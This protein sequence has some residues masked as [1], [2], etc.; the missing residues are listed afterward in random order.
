D[1]G[2]INVGE[3]EFYLRESDECGDLHYSAQMFQQPTFGCE[4]VPDSDPT[5]PEYRVRVHLD[6]ILDLK[7]FTYLP[8]PAGVLVPE[9]PY[10]Y[11]RLGFRRLGKELDPTPEQLELMGLDAE[12][13]SYTLVA[14]GTFLYQEIWRN[15]DLKIR[16]D[17]HK[18]IKPRGDS[19]QMSMSHCNI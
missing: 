17:K 6:F 4:I 14:T 2:L 7:T 5:A 18:K 8:S 1:T 16:F 12:G 19:G 15:Y 11:L 3:E 13:K 9:G 10:R